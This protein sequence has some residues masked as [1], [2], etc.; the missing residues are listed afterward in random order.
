MDRVLYS[1]EETE[2]RADRGRDS[3]E[4]TAKLSAQ[5]LGNSRNA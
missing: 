4:K 1:I 3:L 5:T 2:R